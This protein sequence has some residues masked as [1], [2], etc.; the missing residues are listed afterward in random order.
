MGF[1][2]DYKESIKLLLVILI[3]VGVCLFIINTYIDVYYK[4]QLLVNPCGVCTE[5]YNVSCTKEIKNNND[6]SYLTNFNFSL[7]P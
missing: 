2:V 5:K 6:L 7:D 3:T 4:E 1:T